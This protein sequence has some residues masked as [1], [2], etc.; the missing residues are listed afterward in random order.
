MTP[1]QGYLKQAS[2]DGQHSEQVELWWVCVSESAP[3]NS[4]EKVKEPGQDVL[5]QGGILGTLGRSR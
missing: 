5:I 3:C 2:V 4:T 1:R